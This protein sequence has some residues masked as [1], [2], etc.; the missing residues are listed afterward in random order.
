MTSFLENT[1]NKTAKGVTISG[2]S[3]QKG[4]VSSEL[5]IL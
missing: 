3:W 2:K 4:E 5:R 1:R